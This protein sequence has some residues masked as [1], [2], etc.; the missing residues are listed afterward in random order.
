M[1]GATTCAE[2]ESWYDKIVSTASE[3]LLNGQ[4]LFFRL[5]GYLS[6]LQVREDTIWSLVIGIVLGIAVI[7]FLV[8]NPGEPFD[9]SKRD[10]GQPHPEK[11]TKETDVNS[12]SVK[13][14]KDKDKKQEKE[15]SEK[16]QGPLKFSEEAILKRTGRW[17]KALGLTEE[18]VRG[19]VKDTNAEIEATHAAEVAGKPLP[20]SNNV[21]IRSDGLSLSRIV[22]IVVLGGGL[23]VALYFM[24]KEYNG[25]VVNVLR[26]MFP[27]EAETLGFSRP[28]QMAQMPS[29]PVDTEEIV[30]EPEV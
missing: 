24:N 11:K 7:V 22:D 25:A 17:S 26:D 14:D 10:G 27:R 5:K 6:S 23:L 9:Y 8:L 3:Y 19:I 30:F 21:N 16:K 13:K 18:Q 2:D 29:M 4:I 28:D 15:E 20:E 12:A 1:A